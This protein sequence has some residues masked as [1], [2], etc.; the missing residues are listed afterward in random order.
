[1]QAGDRAHELNPKPTIALVRLRE[2]RHR[3]HRSDD[4]CRT[5]APLTARSGTSGGLG[6][7]LS[8]MDLHDSARH[9][10]LVPRRVD[11]RQGE[12]L[13]MTVLSGCMFELTVVDIDTTH[14]PVTVQGSEP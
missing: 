11:G 5:H 4:S 14:T 12:D 6:F 3:F 2:P 10:V 8:G 13:R 7:S 9:C 1:M